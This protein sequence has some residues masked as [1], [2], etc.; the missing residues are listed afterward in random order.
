MPVLY[1]QELKSQCILLGH[2]RKSHPCVSRWKFH[3]LKADLVPTSAIPVHLVEKELAEHAASVVDGVLHSEEGVV[4]LR[5]GA[6]GVED[7]P[8]RQLWNDGSLDH[9]FLLKRKLR[10]YGNGEPPPVLPLWASAWIDLHA[11]DA[12]QPV[13][14]RHDPLHAVGGATAGATRRRWWLVPPALALMLAA[15]A[16]LR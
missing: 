16:A 8:P 14:A 7:L 6:P 9:A 4:Y 12:Q 11:A 15:A 3:Y 2:G 5:S 1:N 13:A 10:Q